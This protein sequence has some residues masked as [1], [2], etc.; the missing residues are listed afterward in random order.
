MTQEAIQTIATMMTQWAQQLK[1]MERERIVREDRQE[2][3]TT[4]KRSKSRGEKRRKRSTI[5]RDKN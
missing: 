5:R 3:K 1:E 4:R 2:N